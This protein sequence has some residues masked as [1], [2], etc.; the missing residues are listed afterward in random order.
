MTT[1]RRAALLLALALLGPGLA[2][3]GGGND[4]DGDAA[5]ASLS[6]D[7]GT[8]TEEVDDDDG[9]GG[10]A[11]P[12]REMSAEQQDAILE[13]AQCM[14]DHGIDMPDPEISSDG[15]VMIRGGGPGDAPEGGPGD[16]EWEAA[17]EACQP[18]MD[19]AMPEVEI[20]P[21]EQAEMQ[22]Q[23]VEVAQCMRERGYDMPD[24][25]VDGN[26][27]ITVEMG[28]PDGG[29]DQGEVM[30]PDDEQQEDMEECQEAAGMEGG[31][32]SVG[33]ADGPGGGGGSTE[34]DA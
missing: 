33:G 24:P 7:D 23:M 16:E 8:E 10:G 15:G 29:G 12:E 19:E 9:D 26:G 34:G 3:C 14:R 30:P 2:A 4:D 11:Q 13:F 27:R 5:V 28:A 32:G 1:R 20:D 18:I 6:G 25:Q 22:D 21:E 17:N 31:P